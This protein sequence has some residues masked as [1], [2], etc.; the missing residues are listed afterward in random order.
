MEGSYFMGRG[1]T[2]EQFPLLK[3]ESLRG[4]LVYYDGE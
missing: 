4:S 1:K 3:G 2:M